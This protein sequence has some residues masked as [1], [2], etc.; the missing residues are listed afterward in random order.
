MG[1]FSSIGKQET[2]LFANRYFLPHPTSIA[3][4][5]KYKPIYCLS[6]PTLVSAR[7]IFQNIANTRILGKFSWRY[8]LPRI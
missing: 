8:E 1:P 6:L 3:I 2:N 5:D 4:L 7:K